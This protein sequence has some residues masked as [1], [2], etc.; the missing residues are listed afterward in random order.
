MIRV[1]NAFLEKLSADHDEQHFEPG[2][3]FDC[4]R[5]ICRQGDG[6]TLLHLETFAGDLD[7]RLAIGD[8]HKSIERR[9]VFA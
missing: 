3:C 1:S 6:L 9:G 2:S 4:M 7:V 5:A 8:H